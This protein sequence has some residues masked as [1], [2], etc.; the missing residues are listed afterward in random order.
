MYFIYKVLKAFFV[1]PSHNVKRCS[2]IKIYQVKH[3]PA[4]IHSGYS[5][6]VLLSH[7]WIWDF[8]HFC[9][10]IWLWGDDNHQLTHLHVHVDCLRNVSLKITTIE[11]VVSSYFITHLHQIFTVLLKKKIYWINLNLDRISPLNE[12]NSVKGNWCKNYAR[13]HGDTTLIYV[14]L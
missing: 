9:E 4:F 1:S 8:R 11:N 5:C 13:Q 2:H 10:K 7:S 3:Y 6:A 14:H 12:Q